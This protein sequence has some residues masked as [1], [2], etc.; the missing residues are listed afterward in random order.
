MPKPNE[1]VRHVLDN[2]L[3]VQSGNCPLENGKKKK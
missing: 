3:K 2:V 1:D